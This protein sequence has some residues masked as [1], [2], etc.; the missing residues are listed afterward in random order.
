[1]EA[2]GYGDTPL[3]TACRHGRSASVETIELLVDAYAYACPENLTE[4][5]QNQQTALR[6]KDIKWQ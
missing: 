6:S 2:M 3:H 5:N 4:V 1:M